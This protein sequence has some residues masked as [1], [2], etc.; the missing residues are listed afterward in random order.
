[1]VALWAGPKQGGG[2]LAPS[3]GYKCPPG[4]GQNRGWLQHTPRGILM[5]YAWRHPRVVK[6][7][8]GGRWDRMEDPPARRS[9]RC[10]WRA[11]CSAASAAHPSSPMLFSSKSAAQTRLHWYWSTYRHFHLTL[12]YHSQQSRAAQQGP[13]GGVSMVWYRDQKRHFNQ[14][15]KNCQFRGALGVILGFLRGREN[16]WF[17]GRSKGQICWKKNDSDYLWTQT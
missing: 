1:M 12:K 4:L 7:Q 11:L 10:N 13:V 5:S 16:F 3:L 8:S 6:I 17:Y 2:G 14:I 15:S 9:N